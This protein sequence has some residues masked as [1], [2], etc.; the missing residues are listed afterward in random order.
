MH[1]ISQVLVHHIYMYI[2][3]NDRHFH[4]LLMYHIGP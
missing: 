3:I 4:T 2:Y 1:E